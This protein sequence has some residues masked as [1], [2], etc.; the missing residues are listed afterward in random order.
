MDFLAETTTRQCEFEPFDSD[1]NRNEPPVDCCLAGRPI[2][3]LC[4][5][6][7]GYLS[8]VFPTPGFL[9]YP[10]SAE[11]GNRIVPLL[12]AGWK[13]GRILYSGKVEGNRHGWRPRTNPLRRS[14][15][16]RR[17]LEHARRYP[18]CPQ[19]SWPFVPHIERW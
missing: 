5:R 11:Y 18:F 17:N 6:C 8:I 2:D 13:V 4:S 15:G 14:A 16:K 12:V 9:Q 1:S 7:T 19:Y 10:R 3:H